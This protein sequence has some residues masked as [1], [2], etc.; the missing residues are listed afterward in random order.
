MTTK[1]QFIIILLLEKKKKKTGE[2]RICIYFNSLRHIFRKR[3]GTMLWSATTPQNVTI[4]ELQDDLR[5]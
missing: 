3:E 1:K 4:L 2:F 5:S